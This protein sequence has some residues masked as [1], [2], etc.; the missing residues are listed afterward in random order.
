MSLANRNTQRRLC[1]GFS[2]VEVMVAL[3]VASIGL[4]GLA[5]METLS[6]AS[7]GVASMRSL[8]AIQASRTSP[9]PC[10]RIA[11]TGRPAMRRRWPPFK[12]ISGGAITITDPTGGLSSGGVS[13]LTPGATSCNGSQMAAYDVQQWAAAVQA[14]LPGSLSTLTCTT[15]IATPITLYDPDPMG[16]ERGG[17]ERAADDDQYAASADLRVVR[18][19]MTQMPP[20]SPTL[21]SRQ[22][23]VTLIELMIAI[24]IG[25]FLTGALLTLVQA[26]KSRPSMTQGGLSQLQDNERM[27]M[28]LIADVIQSAGYYPQPSPPVNTA[29]T[30][31][32]IVAPF[33][34]T[35]Q[36]GQAIVGTGNWTDPPPGNTISVRYVSGGSGA[37][38]FDNTINCTGNPVAAQTTFV[39]NFSLAADPAFS[40]HL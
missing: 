7:T 2:L 28:T 25:L 22:R 8:A 36:T 33:N 26:M 6:I 9:P 31:F 10:M 38:A 34:L 12:L 3:V 11:A 16:G 39:N 5:K 15:V 37:P 4:L 14:L 13:C 23:G 32:P 35:G 18:A 29:A 27:A 1:R 20:R 17:G 24:L 40:R 30:M 21:S 19:A